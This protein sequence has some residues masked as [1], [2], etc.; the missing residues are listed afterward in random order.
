MPLH[1]YRRSIGVGLELVIRPEDTE[2]LELIKGD[3]GDVG[4]QGPHGAAS[5]VPGPKGEKGD[6]GEQGLTI[7][8]PQGPLG[9]PG[10]R[11][12]QGDVPSGALILYPADLTPPEGYTPVEPPD[13]QKW[14]FLWAPAIP[15][16]ILKK[17]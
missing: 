5:T 15:P 3:K 4:S 2:L 13:A 1:E 6:R 16:V 9:L 12:A 10:P 14:A 11:G 17:V 8:G 7:T